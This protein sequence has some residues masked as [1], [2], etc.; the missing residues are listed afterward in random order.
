MTTSHTAPPWTAALSA[1]GQSSRFGTDK[2]LAPWRG[3]PLIWHAAQAV[4]DASERLLVAPQGRYDLTALDL[5][6][7]R[8]VS[9]R[10]P[11]EG[12]LAGLETALAAARHDWVAYAGVDMPAL[13]PAYWQA[14]LDAR[15]PGCRS[16]QAVNPARGP[17]P[18]GALYHRDLLPW[19]TARLDA[20]ER[21]LRLACPVA[22]VVEVH[23]LSSGFFGNVNRPADLAGLEVSEG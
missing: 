15:A 11:G 8:T 7:W 20:G 9:D 6:G 21:R 10:R 18:L 12:P 17:Q 1:G 5:S 22:E 19:V 3:H 13:T 2:A 14:L 4:Q 16:V 23:G